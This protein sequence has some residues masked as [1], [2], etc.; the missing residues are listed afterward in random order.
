MANLQENARTG[1]SPRLRVSRW[2]SAA[3]PGVIMA[4][5]VHRLAALGRETIV[6]NPAAQRSDG[7]ESMSPEEGGAVTR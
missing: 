7:D 3:I 6:E 2:R 1:G 4:P 5:T